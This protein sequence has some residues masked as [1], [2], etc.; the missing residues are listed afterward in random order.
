MIFARAALLALG[1]LLPGIPGDAGAQST[2]WD[3]KYD[4][5]RLKLPIVPVPPS[6]KLDASTLNSTPAPYSAGGLQNPGA[7]SSQPS[8]G[9]RLTIPSR[10]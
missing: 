8:P 2:N 10:Q 3:N 7:S 6:S 9:L 1:I 4:L 5:N